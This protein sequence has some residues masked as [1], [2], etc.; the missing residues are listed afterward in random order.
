LANLLGND[1][2]LRIHLVLILLERRLLRDEVGER[3][4]DDGIVAAGL[5]GGGGGLGEQRE[6]EGCRTVL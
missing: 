5:R 3:R 4:Q 6:P 2:D 1:G